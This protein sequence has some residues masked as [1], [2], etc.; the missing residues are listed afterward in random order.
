MPYDVIFK[1]T[2]LNGVE[3][4]R[5]VKR[6]QR[7]KDAGELV[8]ELAQLSVVHVDGLFFWG[9]LCVNRSAFAIWSFDVVKAPLL[10]RGKVKGGA[11]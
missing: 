11:K 3:V 8:R 6:Y 2:L 4:E 1:G 5:K 7:R 10:L 9:S